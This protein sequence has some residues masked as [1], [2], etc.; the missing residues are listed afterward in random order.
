[1][2]RD[3]SSDS[4]STGIL[5]YLSR[6]LSKAKSAREWQL[7][8]GK[9]LTEKFSDLSSLPDQTSHGEVRAETLVDITMLPIGVEAASQVIAMSNHKE[10]V[11]LVQACLDLE[12]VSYARTSGILTGFRVALDEEGI[13]DAKPQSNDEDVAVFRMLVIKDT[14]KYRRAA[15]SL[16]DSESEIT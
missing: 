5:N 2:V 10:A 16:L 1:M 9:A 7:I 15:L 6:V 8:L 12:N 13:Y 11:L 4:Y 14:A 3:E